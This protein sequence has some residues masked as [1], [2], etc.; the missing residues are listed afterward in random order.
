MDTVDGGLYVRAYNGV[1]SRWHKAA[2]RHKAGQIVAAGMTND[3][4][5]G[6]VEGQINDRID[7][8]YRAR[9]RGSPYLSPMVGARARAATV[10]IT[11]AGS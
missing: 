5:F 10:R 8:A 1:N 2:L 3:V 11:P 6:A 7:E 9:R 4:A